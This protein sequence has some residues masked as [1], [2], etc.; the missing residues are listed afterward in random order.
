MKFLEKNKI[1]RNRQFG[2][3]KKHS[4]VHGL[5][6]LTEDI[7]KSIDEGK[8][9]CGVFIDLQK[10]FDTVEHKILLKKLETTDLEE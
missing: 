9:S 10:A 6:T 2:F 7:K 8:L 4:T 3:R 1:L 5:V